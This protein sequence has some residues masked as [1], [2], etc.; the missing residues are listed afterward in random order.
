MSGQAMALAW[1]L[2]HQLAQAVIGQ[3]EDA[4]SGRLLSCR[5]CLAGGPDS[6]THP[7]L[8]AHRACCPA[9]WGR[10]LKRQDL[11]VILCRA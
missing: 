8:A 3:P 11:K 5:P 6:G 10:G 1:Q 2:R 9:L 4:Q 7:W